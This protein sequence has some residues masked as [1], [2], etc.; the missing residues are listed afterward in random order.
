[1][2]TEKKCPQCQKLDAY[3]AVRPGS[4]LNLEA[5]RELVDRLPAMRRL[6][7]F[8]QRFVALAKEMGERYGLVP[9]SYPPAP[10][11]GELSWFA[12]L[13][14][15]NRELEQVKDTWAQCRATGRQG[16]Y[17]I[18]YRGGAE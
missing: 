1:M 13:K 18:A 10:K 16:L 14:A 12:H 11:P 9:Y 8:S 3:E 6:P 17:G 15:A 5:V 7:D 4:V 2:N